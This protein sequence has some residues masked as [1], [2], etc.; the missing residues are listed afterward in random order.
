MA[1]KIFKWLKD[2]S[3]TNEDD[4]NGFTPLQL[5]VKQ[6]DMSSIKTLIK[7]GADV[8]D[9]SSCDL[10]PLHLAAFAGNENAVKILLKHG[11]NINVLNSAKTGTPLF[12]AI[13]KNHIEIARLLL[14]KGSDPNLKVVDGDTSL[15]YASIVA[16]LKLSKCY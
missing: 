7:N 8:N 12:G 16:E 14:E 4:S 2:I 15:T 9:L 6:N 1:S 10:S 11:A 5:A 3:S 13:L